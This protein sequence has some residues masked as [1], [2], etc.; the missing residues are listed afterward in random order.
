MTPL[1]KTPNNIFDYQFPDQAFLIK[2][3]ATK[4]KNL[5]TVVRVFKLEKIIKILDH[6][7]FDSKYTRIIYFDYRNSLVIKRIE[8]HESLPIYPNLCPTLFSNLLNG[9]EIQIQPIVD[10]EDE[11]AR[12]YWA[13]KFKQDLPIFDCKK[14]NV[15]FLKGIPALIDW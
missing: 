6:P 10:I 9:R 12:E 8:R 15:G 4:C 14:D 5:S 13:A 7:V 1:R 2:D 3:F 11:A